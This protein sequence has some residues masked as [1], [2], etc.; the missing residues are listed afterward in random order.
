[1]KE[2]K[3][4][5]A[6]RIEPSFLKELQNEAKNKNMTFSGYVRYILNNRKN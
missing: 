4:V 5:I 6:F 3:Y 1:M 2:N